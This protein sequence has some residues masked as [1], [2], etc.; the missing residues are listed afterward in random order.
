MSS[1]TRRVGIGSLQYAEKPTGI[2]SLERTRC[3]LASVR[4]F[5]VR[6]LPYCDSSRRMMSREGTGRSLSVVRFP[7]FFYLDSASHY[8]GS[9]TRL[10]T[11]PQLITEMH[12][13]ERAAHDITTVFR[14]RGELDN[15]T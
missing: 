13:C 11:S 6:H 9:G 2:A 14:H 8:L 3:P 12:E 4:H 10:V 7:V 5:P 1:K 15:G